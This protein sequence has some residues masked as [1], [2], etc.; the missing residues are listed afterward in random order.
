MNAGVYYNEDIPT[1]ESAECDRVR[2]AG[3]LIGGSVGG[4]IAFCLLCV[5]VYFCC[6]KKKTEPE[7]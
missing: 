4:A 7:P 2:A 3:G 6:C 5:C 1:Y